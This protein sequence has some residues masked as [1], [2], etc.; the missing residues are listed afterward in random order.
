MTKC[1]M[2]RGVLL[3]L[4]LTLC[5]AGLTGLT[6]EGRYAAAEDEEAEIVKFS[7]KKVNH[8]IP[9]IVGSGSNE[10]EKAVMEAIEHLYGKITMII[11][12]HRLTKIEKCNVIYKLKNQK[13]E[14]IKG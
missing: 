7:V 11:V 8:R 13:I 5:L 6:G 9:L 1:R 3:I 10:T 12:A 4:A 14:K 2:F